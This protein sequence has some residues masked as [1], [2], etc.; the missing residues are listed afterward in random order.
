MIAAA[1]ATAENNSLQLGAR[2]C[3]SRVTKSRTGVRI[4]MLHS[5]PDCI[6]LEHGDWSNDTGQSVVLLVPETFAAIVS[7][8]S[9]CVRRA[10]RQ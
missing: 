9:L 3:W 7:R 8:C 1:L 6:Y 2:A 10:A 4:G 5:S